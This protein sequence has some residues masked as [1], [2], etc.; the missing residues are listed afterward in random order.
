MAELPRAPVQ[1][2]PEQLR[3]KQEME[4]RARMGKAL[5]RIRHKVIVMS[6]KGGVG[7]TTVAVNLAASLAARGWAT[8]I[9]DMDL[10]GPDVPLMLGVEGQRFPPSVSLIVPVEAP[11]PPVKVVSI[12]F[13]LQGDQPVVWRG[14]LKAHALQQFLGDVAW[15]DLDFL[16]VDL[17]PGTSDEPL[18]VA[19]SIVDADGVVIVT[20]PQAVST[21][22]VRKSVE[23]AR[24]MKLRVLGVLEN[25]SGFTCPHCGEHYD[26]FGAGGGGERLAAEANVPFLGRIP[27]D[28]QLVARGDEGRPFVRS[29]PEAPAA[30]AFERAV[31]ALLHAVSEPARKL[32]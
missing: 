17:P 24:L 12:S 29:M 20:T 4:R 31:D 8:G 3:V 15:G 5:G 16:V 13:I 22:D 19:E 28:V 11:D 30:V 1:L 6:G 26:V 2:T 25:M 32:P 7:K 23:F 9:L 14:P 27:M 18:A 10:T 21:L